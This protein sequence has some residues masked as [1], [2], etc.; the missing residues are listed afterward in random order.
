MQQLTTNTTSSTKPLAILRQGPAPQP[1]LLRSINN[2]K[3]LA[4]FF[5]ACIVSILCTLQLPVRWLAI[6]SWFNTLL[7]IASLA[8]MF[9]VLGYGFKKRQ[10]QDLQY[11]LLNQLQLRNGQAH[12]G[13]FALPALSQVAMGTYSVSGA[14]YVHLAWNG[15]HFW[16][17]DP[18]ELPEVTSWFQTQFPGIRIVT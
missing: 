1:G 17:F 9:A 16:A 18:A 4:L 7:H 12:I 3:L 14:A 10:T 13:D 5:I 11:S 8:T 15:D 2:P 6:P